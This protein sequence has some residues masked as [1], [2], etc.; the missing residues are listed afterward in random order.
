VSR[1][2]SV[3]DSPE[4]VAEHMPTYCAVVIVIGI[5]AEDVVQRR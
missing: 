2:V 5:L 1:R 4:F 3:R